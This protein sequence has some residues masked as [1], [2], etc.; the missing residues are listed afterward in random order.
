MYD[1]TFQIELNWIGLGGE[2]VWKFTFIE[3]NQRNGC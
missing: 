3:E 1:Q 2:G